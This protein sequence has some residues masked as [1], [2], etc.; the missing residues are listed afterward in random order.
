MIRADGELSVRVDAVGGD[1]AARVAERPEAWLD[2]AYQ[3]V[4]LIHGF[5]NNQGEACEAFENFMGLLPRG[6]GRVGR[7]FWPGDADFGFFQWLDFLSYPT[8]IPD[9]R[10]SA[11]RLAA[12]L[13]EVA[14]TTPGIAFSLVGHSMGC[15]LILEMLEDLGTRPE[16]ERPSIRLIMLMAAAVPVE[17]AED[18]ERLRRAGDL[19]AERLVLYSPDDLVLHYAFPAG[20]TLAF[21]MGNEDAVYLEAVG[22][23]GNPAGFATELPVLRSGN[24]HGSYWKDAAAAAMLAR[25][26][27][28]AVANELAE[29]RTPENET[30]PP[31][32]LSTRRPPARSLVGA[33]WSVC[34]ERGP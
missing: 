32:A 8:E 25:K 26:L 11:A 28:G 33:D 14:Q 7:F 31:R 15:R 2:G 29:N 20:Q 22:R 19:A 13:V 17:L 21:G 18:G 3:V 6:L 23:F 1:V 4:L 27:G 10:E 5:N 12:R 9:A 24:R 34:V 30:A 16:A